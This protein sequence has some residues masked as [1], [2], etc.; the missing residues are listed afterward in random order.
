MFM[1]EHLNYDISVK[2]AKF[3]KSN[4]ENLEILISA[5]IFSDDINW[6]L[7]KLPWSRF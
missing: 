2:F 4:L 1:K 6:R 5:E 3:L 7:C